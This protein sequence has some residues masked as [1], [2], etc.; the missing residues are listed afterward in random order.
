M[1]VAPSRKNDWVLTREALDQLLMR[2]DTDRERAGEQYERVRRKLV[3][4]FEWRGDESA[5][6]HADETIN[7]VAR[8]VAEGEQ[9]HH[10]DSYFGGVARLV[11]LESLKAREKERT[12]LDQLPSPPSI[13]ADCDEAEP[14]L[15]CFET[16]LHGL[17]A[18][19]RALIVEYYQEEQRAKIERRKELA[20]RLHIPLNALRIRAHRIRVQLEECV[21]ECVK[22]RTG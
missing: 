13:V 3:K 1:R 11:W 4:F 12:A 14:R 15:V 17:A 20:A 5:A 6:E 19:S 8:K 10:L 7:R 18:D 9:I 21:A 16:C 2:L 22:Q